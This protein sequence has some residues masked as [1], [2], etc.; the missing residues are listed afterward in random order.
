MEIKDVIALVGLIIPGITAAVGVYKLLNDVSW[1]LSKTTKFSHIL[2]N[3]REYIDPSELEFMKAEIKR[4][5]KKSILGMVNLKLRPLILYIRTYSE[6][7]MPSW[8]WWFLAPHIQCK[9]DRFFIRYKGKYKRYRLYSKIAAIFYLVYGLIFLCLLL[10]KGTV[11][12]VLGVVVMLFCLFTVFMFWTLFPGR[13][14][15]N[16][17]NLQLLKVDASKYQVK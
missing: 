11:Y 3:Y 17:Y 6:L 1:F 7:D 4:E 13:E 16:K 8:R 2:E 9:Y 5:I 10:N 12:M 14:V 15:I